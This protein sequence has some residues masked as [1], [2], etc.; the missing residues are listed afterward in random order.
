MNTPNTIM[1]FTKNKPSFTAI[2]ILFRHSIRMAIMPNSTRK[3][4][5][6]LKTVE[7]PMHSKLLI[8]NM[9]TLQKPKDISSR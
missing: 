3:L 4:K 5:D 2:D 9:I 8:Y 6:I 1:Y 7:A